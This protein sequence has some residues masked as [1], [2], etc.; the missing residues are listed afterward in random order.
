MDTYDEIAEIELELWDF[1]KKPSRLVLLGVFVVVC[2][3]LNV[4]FRTYS[5]KPDLRG[6]AV[7]FLRANYFQVPAD[8]RASIMGT[9]HITSSEVVPVINNGS[10][11]YGD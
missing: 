7:Q 2:I 10:L 11:T 1:I 3:G 5:L 6:Q 4:L 8:E 9:Y